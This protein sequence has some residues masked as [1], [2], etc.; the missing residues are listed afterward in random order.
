[1]SGTQKS[2]DANPMIIAIRAIRAKRERD[3]LSRGTVPCPVC[4][5]DLNYSVS[6][7]NGHVH[8]QCT[9]PGCLAWMM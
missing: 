9:K 4:G 2:E 1:M 3:N 8:G 6:S 7:Y 5:S